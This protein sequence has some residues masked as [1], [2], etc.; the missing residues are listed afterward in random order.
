MRMFRRR[1][2]SH[3]RAKR[4]K[5][6]AQSQFRCECLPSSKS[7][8]VFHFKKLTVKFDLLYLLCSNWSSCL[9]YREKW[10]AVIRSYCKADP[11]IKETS[12]FTL[13]FLTSMRI[14]RRVP[15]WSEA[16]IFVCSRVKLTICSF[17]SSKY[18]RCTERLRR[19]CLAGFCFVLIW[20]CV[21]GCYTSFVWKMDGPASTHRS[22]WQSGRLFLSCAGK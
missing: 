18:K 11:L 14:R 12:V 17:C 16:T 7:R 20:Q 22:E 13:S 3:L 19:Q 21:A 5:V 10:T 4:K 15:I 8:Q 2:G 6:H 9:L 1:C